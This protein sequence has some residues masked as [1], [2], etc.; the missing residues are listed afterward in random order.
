[1]V[2]AIGTLVLVCRRMLAES[3]DDMRNQVLPALASTHI[4]KMD[5]NNE[6]DA[7]L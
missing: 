5:L 7:V 4:V 2:D 6:R 1:M 3:R